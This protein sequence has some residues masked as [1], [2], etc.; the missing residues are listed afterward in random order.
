[1][2]CRERLLDSSAIPALAAHARVQTDRIT[3]HPILLGPEIALELSESGAEILSL[4]DGVKTLA[5]IARSLADEYDADP[6]EIQADAAEF[7]DRLAAKGYVRVAEQ[8]V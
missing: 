7:L 6:A 1:M 4:C 3:G 5:E 2:R 8:P